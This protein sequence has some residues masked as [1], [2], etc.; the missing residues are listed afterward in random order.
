MTTGAGDD[1]IGTTTTPSVFTINFTGNQTPAQSGLTTALSMYRINSPSNSGQQI[2]ARHFEN[3]WIWGSGTFDRA[4]M[5]FTFAEIEEARVNPEA[6]G[7][8]EV[9]P[10]MMKNGQGTGA[11][12]T[13]DGRRV[14][15]Q[16]HKG[17][18]IEQRPQADG[19]VRT[20]KR[21]TK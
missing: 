21:I 14:T 10:E 1:R 4:D 17:I 3:D 18:Y 5:V 13:L 12:Y 15:R 9:K 6:D 2:R 11:I 20:V 7:I 8:V 19:T 16:N